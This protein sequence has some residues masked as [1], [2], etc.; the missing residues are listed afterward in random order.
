[1]LLLASKV[2]CDVFQP[3]FKSHSSFFMTSSSCFHRGCPYYHITQIHCNLMSKYMKNVH[4]TRLKLPEQQPI[5]PLCLSCPS[6][7]QK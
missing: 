3:H 2:H 1:M 6:G 5:Y 4:S 7:G